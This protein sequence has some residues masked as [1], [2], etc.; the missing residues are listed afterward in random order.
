MNNF[1]SEIV[2]KKVLIFGLGRQGG[3]TGDAEWL[4]SHGATVRLSDKDTTLVKEGQTREQIDWA[5]IIIKNPGVPDDNELILYAKK[6][7]KPVYTSIALFVKYAPVKTIGVTGTRGKSTTVAL[8]ADLLEA[9]Y[10]GQVIRGGN[11]AGTSCLSLFDSLE[12]VA[13]AALELSSFQLHNFHELRVSPNIA[14]VTNLYPDHLNRYPSMDEYRLDKEAICKYQDKTDL[15]IYN[16]DNPGAIDIS[17]GSVAIH[18]PY[19]SVQCKDWQ[20]TLPGAHNKENIAAMAALARELGIKES[21]ARDVVADFSGVPF[22]QEVI[23]TIA[24][25]TYIN[26]TTAT[27]PTAAQKALLAATT[28]TIWITGGDTKKLP[29]FD[30][31]AEAG[32]C[33]LLKKIVILGSKN[34]PDYVNALKDISGDKIVGTAMSMVEAVDLAKSLAEPGDTIL[35]S[36]GF[37]SFDLFENEFDRGRQFNEYVAS[38]T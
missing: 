31:I 18:V 36:P 26:D 34:I 10:P 5:E 1:Q 12:G 4:K 6:S 30:L 33:P 23:A 11:I 35:L 37:A 29:F 27:T 9:A 19:S 17:R 8:I 21:V 24:G 14:V 28:P 32:S 25:V 7:G 13:Y 38:L 20:T 15:C 16:S 3:G 2:G 22:R